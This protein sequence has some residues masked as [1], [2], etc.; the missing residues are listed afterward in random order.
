ML[1]PFFRLGSCAITLLIFQAC[2]SDN[3]SGPPP[4]QAGQS[5]QVAAN[6]YPGI[7]PKTLKGD[8]QCLTKVPG[9]YCTHLCQTDQ[10]CCAV[11]GECKTGRPQVCAPFESTGQMFCFLSC[12]GS[13]VSGAGYTDSNLYCQQNANAAFGC[14]STGGGAANRKICSP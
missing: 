3:N 13:E 8:V 14:R 9:G 2:G 7:D 1:K 5:C 11:Q 10:D 6:C 12:E 4:E